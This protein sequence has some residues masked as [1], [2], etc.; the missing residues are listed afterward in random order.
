MKWKPSI[1]GISKSGEFGI[2]S[3]HSVQWRVEKLR[4][5]SLENRLGSSMEMPIV[6]RK[7]IHTHNCAAGCTRG[8]FGSPESWVKIHDV[9][10]LCILRKFKQHLSACKRQ[11]AYCSARPSHAD[12]KH[13]APLE[14]PR[15]MMLPSPRLRQG[16]FDFELQAP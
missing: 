9:P 13:T 1:V 8:H 3:C 2:L 5:G 7:L 4:F 10:D 15:H 16:L 14:L 6:R 11:G 12:N